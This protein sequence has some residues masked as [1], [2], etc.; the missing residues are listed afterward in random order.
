MSLKSKHTL[1]VKQIAQELGFSFC[2]ISKSGF[3][4]IEAKDFESWLKKGNNGKMTYM[5]NYFD[6]RVDTTLLVPDSKSVITLMSNYYSDYKQNPENPKISRYAFGNDYHEVIKDKLKQFFILIN[7]KIGEVSGRY[8]VDSAPVMEK[9]WAKKSGLVWQ[10]KNT[11]V[12]HP[13]N[14]SFFFLSEI[15]LDL[16]LDYSTPIKDYCGTCTKCID[17]CPTNALTPYS[18]NGSKCISYLTIELK[19]ELIP[20]EFHQKLENWIF[21]CDICQEV[22][23]WNKFSLVHNEIQFEPKI[24][25]LEMN[26]K[27]WQELSEE[28]FKIL[29]KNSPLKRSKWKGLKR[30]VESI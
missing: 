26:K 6:K 11:N 13:K 16:E 19:D 8:F 12:I 10:G 17:S 14:G 5:E 1:I 9:A 27:Q 30:N 3:L 2:G 18:I 15:I 23:P 29:A 7:Q 22:C 21:G 28:Q 4:E 24:N 25:L 20:I